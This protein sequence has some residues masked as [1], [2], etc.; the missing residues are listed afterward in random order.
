MLDPRKVPEGL[1]GLLPLA[2]RW[3]IGDDGYRVAAVEAASDQ[4]LLELIAA[5]DT[6]DERV[7]WQW[8]EGP[9]A[10]SHSPTEEYLAI[11]CLTMAIDTAE[12]VLKARGMR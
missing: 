7:L 6:I 2:E 3:G 10:D 5:L 9:E 12:S 8:L 11:T 1:A 4:D